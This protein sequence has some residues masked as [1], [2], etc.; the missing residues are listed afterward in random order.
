MKRLNILFIRVPTTI[1]NKCPVNWQ[2]MAGFV[3]R[4]GFDRFD[5]PYSSV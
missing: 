1:G 3:S 2:L 4:D 5:L